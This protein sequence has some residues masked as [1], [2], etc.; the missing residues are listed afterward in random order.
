MKGLHHV[1]I[2]VKDL[3]ASIRFYHDVLG[4]EFSNEPSPWFDGEELGK[5]VGVPGG[6]L[7]QVS[8]LLGDTMLELLEYKSPPSQT[9]GP[10]MS[11]SLGASHVALPRRRHRRRRRPSSRP[12][13]SSSSATSTSSTRACS[14]AGA[15]CTSRIRTATRSSSSRWRT[16]TRTSARRGSRST[17]QRARSAVDG[18][19]RRAAPFEPVAA[20]VSSRP[21]AAAVRASG[22]E[23]PAP[24]PRARRWPGPASPRAGGGRRP[25]STCPCS[26]R[27]TS[28]RRP[29]AGSGR[30]AHE[31]VGLE[32]CDGLGHRLLAYALGD[33]EVAHAA[34][35]LAVE[36]P[37]H[38]RLRD[39]EVVL[40]AQPP[41]E[42]AEHDA[43]LARQQ[44]GCR[45]WAAIG[46][47]LIRRRRQIA[48]VTCRITL[49]GSSRSTLRSASRDAHAGGSLQVG[50]AVERDARRCCSRRSTPRSR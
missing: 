9:D 38:R 11:N 35:P 48:Q 6:A 10:L 20:D 39:R 13:A 26:V 24:R 31:P 14:P 44:P 36:A 37:E 17:S 2:T 21:G 23:R 46:P 43:Q 28:A 42:L 5:A 4:L 19:G 41:H 47:I 34:L 30:R 27:A 18:R 32:L 22:S 3:D 50:R 33:C 1:G 7:R 15:G 40:D 16:T 45:P 49:R 29:S 12:R 8:L 25:A